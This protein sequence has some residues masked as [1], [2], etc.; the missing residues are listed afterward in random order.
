[1]NFVI[2]VCH[3]VRELNVTLSQQGGSLTLDD[4][5]LC[6]GAIQS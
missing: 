1:M 6:F 5:E 3:R 4:L 2:Y